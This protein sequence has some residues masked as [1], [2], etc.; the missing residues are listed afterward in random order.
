VA[1]SLSWRFVEAVFSN[2]YHLEVE[3]Q[4]KVPLTGPVIIAG[5]HLSAL[6]IVLGA[7]SPRPLVFI[8]RGDLFGY[9]GLRLVLNDLGIIPVARGNAD[10]G[11]IKAALRVLQ[12]GGAVGIFPEGTRSRSHTLASFKTG[13]AALAI[14]SGAQV[15]PVGISGTDLAWPVG[16]YPRLFRTI[17]LKFGDPIA[18][19]D[20]GDKTNKFAMMALAETV[21]QAVSQLIP[22]KYLQEEKV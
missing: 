9:P 5:N 8:G 3:G 11:A 21:E 6:D 22:A 10:V 16:S 14:R 18:S 15:V 7:V 1:K 17:S 2:L 20:F 12:T 19:K 4:E 13:V